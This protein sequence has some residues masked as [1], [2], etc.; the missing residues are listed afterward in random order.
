MTDLKKTAKE[1]K[2]KK[3]Y[4]VMLVVLFVALTAAAVY[5]VGPGNGPMGKDGFGHHQGGEMGMGPMGPMANLNLS[6]DQLGKMW[7]LKEKYHNDT[8]ALRYELFQKSMELKTIYADPKTSDAAILAKQ[9][10]VN[11][12]RQQMEDKMVQLKLEQRKI[13]TPEQLQKFSEGGCWGGGHGSMRG[14]G[15]ASGNKKFGPETPSKN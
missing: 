11:A 6:K 8:Q 12:L 9:K 5:A 3:G 14:F 15:P 7:Q 2:M 10:E 13:L 4:I 1:A